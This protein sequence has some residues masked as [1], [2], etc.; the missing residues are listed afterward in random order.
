M[1]RGAVLCWK[2]MKLPLTGTSMFLR[3]KPPVDGV[4][5]YASSHIQINWVTVNNDGPRCHG[6]LVF[7]DKM[8]SSESR[9]CFHYVPLC[10]RWGLAHRGLPAFLWQIDARRL[11]AW[12]GLREN[13]LTPSPDGVYEVG[14]FKRHQPTV[15]ESG[16]F[17]RKY[18]SD[19]VE[20]TCFPF[21]D[22]FQEKVFL[23]L[24]LVLCLLLFFSINI[25]FYLY[26]FCTI[27]VQTNAVFYYS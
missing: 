3:S 17:R 23:N 8:D 13:E 26:Y 16:T 20:I 22:N 5:V 10:L 15:S 6:R 19:L 21:T 12:H 11:F 4:D 2:S 24:L 25:L 9:T 14:P 27:F 18:F 7:T 1:R